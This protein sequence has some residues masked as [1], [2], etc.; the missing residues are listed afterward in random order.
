MERLSFSENGTYSGLEASIHMARYAMAREWCRGRRVLDLACG[1]GYG[2]RLMRDW[3]AVEVIGVDVSQVS[4]E[5]AQH[6][7]GR[8]GIRYLCGEAESAD[9]LLVG[10]QF[11]LIISLETI[12]H[13]NDPIA[14]LRALA[15]LRAPGGVILISCPNDWWY[16][17]TD[18]ERNPYH[19]RKYT[20]DEFMALVTSVLGEPDATGLG[21]PVAGFINLS[22]GE[23]ASSGHAPSQ[24]AM[25][26]SSE[27][28][29]AM[30]VPPESGSVSPP[31]SSYFVARWGGR[32]DYITGAGLLPVPMDVFRNG[33]YS[34]EPGRDVRNSRILG[35]DLELARQ[36]QSRLERI[37][38]DQADRQ[39]AIDKSWEQRLDNV[40]QAGEAKLAEAKALA[41]QLSAEVADLKL[42]LQ[43]ARIRE[44]AIQTENQVMATNVADLRNDKARLAADNGRLQHEVS[45]YA[46]AAHRYFRLRG[47]VPA[48]V[49]GLGRKLRKLRRN[50]E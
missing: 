47:L 4:V 49:L 13:L 21:V 41:A 36:M 50:L 27:F 37:E 12:E 15:R 40:I 17:P 24:I 34:G 20:F 23:L 28:E 7:F 25:M 2:S 1:E 43:S 46:I 33:L 48:S 30:V 5:A 14:Y 38:A 18:A 26:D 22:M 16:Y 32:R 35:A 10:E 19:V 9:T 8:E 44:L 39:Q 6:R 11:D 42:K 45:V 31:N 3:G 29:N